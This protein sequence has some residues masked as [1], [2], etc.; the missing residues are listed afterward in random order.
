MPSA[1]PLPACCRSLVQYIKW[2]ERA[3]EVSAL[4]HICSQAVTGRLPCLTVVPPL[5]IFNVTPPPE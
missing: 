2:D 4:L 3:E 1:P 5:V